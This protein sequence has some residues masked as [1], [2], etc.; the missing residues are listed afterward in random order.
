[1]SWIQE[2]TGQTRL[3]VRC[4]HGRP[5]VHEQTLYSGWWGRYRGS[6]S[7]LWKYKLFEEGEISFTQTWHHTESYNGMKAHSGQQQQYSWD[8]RARL[9]RNGRWRGRACPERPAKPGP[10]WWHLSLRWS[11]GVS[12]IFNVIW[13]P[14]ISLNPRPHP[15]FSPIP[16]PPHPTPTLLLPSVL[17]PRAGTWWWRLMYDLRLW[18]ADACNH[19]A[20]RAPASPEHSNVSSGRA[21]SCLSQLFILQILRRL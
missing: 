4:V 3:D 11:L 12:F 16:T 17:L 13:Q 14:Q 10:P 1:M 5:S 9:T 18:Q 8:R 20:H 21:I 15:R 19:E 7:Q 6:L 2:C